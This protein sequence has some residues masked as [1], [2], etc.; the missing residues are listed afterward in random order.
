[1]TASD[2]VSTAIGSPRA[3]TSSSWYA[4][5]FDK[6]PRRRCVGS[7]PTHVTPATGTYARPGTVRS[8]VYAPEPATNDPF[9][10]TAIIRSYSTVSRSHSTR[11]GLLW[12]PK[13]VSTTRWS[14]ASSSATME[15]ISSATGSRSTTRRRAR[16][17]ISPHGV[18]AVHEVVDRHLGDRCEAGFLAQLAHDRLRRPA[19]AE[20]GS[21]AAERHAHAVEDAHPV[22]DR[23]DRSGRAT[24]RVRL[25]DEQRPAFDEPRPNA[26]QQADGISRVVH[27]VEEAH[28]VE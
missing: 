28:D 14:S 13:D 23:R 9:S 8:K 7:T 2:A 15:R 20:A 5:I 17:A 26:P 1:M 18:H 6:I 22:L 12:P 10:T 27:H 3:T 11:S 4:I 25:E 19:R 21:A 24:G 16:P